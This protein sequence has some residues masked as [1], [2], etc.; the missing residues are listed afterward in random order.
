MDAAA[1]VRLEEFV[2]ATV[3]RDLDELAMRIDALERGVRTFSYAEHLA[4]RRRVVVE[5]RASGLSTQVIAHRLG[6]ARS[7]VERDLQQTPH[8]PPERSV[9]ADSKR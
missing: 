1:H 9:G 3:S 6:L 7:T 2:R 5:L 8:R 4:A